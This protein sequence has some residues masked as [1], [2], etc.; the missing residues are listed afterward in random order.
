MTGDFSIG[1][2]GQLI[3]NGKLVHA[4]NEMNIAGNANDVYNQL[5][6]MGND[7]YPYSS[8]RTPTMYFEGITFSGI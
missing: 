6:A 8:N 3:E 5:V 4:V 7:P 2:V 1:V